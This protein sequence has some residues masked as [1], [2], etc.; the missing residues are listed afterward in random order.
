[1][2]IDVYN[3]RIQSAPHAPVHSHGA[4]HH[5][6]FTCGAF[7]GKSD[8]S[9]LGSDPH[10]ISSLST[11]NM[12][13]KRSHVT[14]ST[15]STSVRDP[16]DV[17]AIGTSNVVCCRFFARPPA[18]TRLASC[19]PRLQDAANQHFGSVQHEI[20]PANSH[21]APPLSLGH[22]R[23]SL[24]LLLR[25]W[26]ESKGGYVQPL[27]LALVRL[28]PRPARRRRPVP[29][30]RRHCGAS[31]VLAMG[32]TLEVRQHQTV[33]YWRHKRTHLDL[34]KGTTYS[35]RRN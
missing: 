30:E 32:R 12:V 6:T 5:T 2:G 19:R 9:V 16:R 35:E 14:L 15:Y 23:R 18:R 1:M 22:S 13:G 20:D 29:E 10:A 34:H 17:S 31:H 3:T 4:F 33:S 28:L 25:H 8:G 27:H 21:S 26:G 7:I 24:R 11:A